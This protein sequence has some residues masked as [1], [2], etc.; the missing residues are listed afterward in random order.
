MN[1]LTVRY[2]NSARIEYQRGSFIA[3]MHKS[4]ND[5]EECDRD[6]EI[7]TIVIYNETLVLMDVLKHFPSLKCVFVDGSIQ[8]V[9]GLPSLNIDNIHDLFFLE[10]LSI[11]DASI[12][13]LEGI[14]FCH[15]LKK[16]K[17]DCISVSLAPLAN[18][19]LEYLKLDHCFYP[20]FRE[21]VNTYPELECI[22][23]YRE[24]GCVNAK[25]LNFRCDSIREHTFARTCTMYSSINV[26]EL[27]L[28]VHFRNG[29]EP[30]PSSTLDNYL[31]RIQATWGSKF[32]ETM[33]QLEAFR[34]LMRK[35]NPE[36]CIWFVKLD[37]FTEGHIKGYTF[38]QI[39]TRS[40]PQKSSCLVS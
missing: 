9:R 12:V 27:H 10:T 28:V 4:S 34:L 37:P 11:N 13:S 14:E 22:N 25:I 36:A 24:L 6:T 32:N 35:S 16:L 30:H 17:I 31:V 15:N 2:F 3:P 19:H 21:H 23:T 40:P 1:E 5:P 33:D 39:R 26:E 20:G 8:R 18:L 38:D 7:V 29:F